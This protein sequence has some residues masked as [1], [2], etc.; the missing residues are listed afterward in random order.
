M[1][2]F[3]HCRFGGALRP[4]QVCRLVTVPMPEWKFCYQPNV[5]DVLLTATAFKSL[6]ES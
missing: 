4:L 3:Q 6:G 2:F 5:H 1:G